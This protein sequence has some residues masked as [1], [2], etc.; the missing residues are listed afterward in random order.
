MCSCEIFNSNS[1][2]ICPHVYIVQHDFERLTSMEFPVPGTVQRLTPRVGER[3]PIWYVME[4][5]LVAET[6][7]KILKCRTCSRKDIDVCE[8]IEEVLKFLGFQD[9]V[10]AKENP[11]TEEWD[12]NSDG[13][14][15]QQQQMLPFPME[16]MSAPFK[17]AVR[18]LEQIGFELLHDSVLGLCLKP[19][20]TPAEIC[21]CGLPFL[22]GGGKL[23]IRCLCIW[24]YTDVE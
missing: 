23:L 9:T 5:G 8:H 21:N 10:L 2:K 1:M 15:R 11:Q 4:G 13:P 17:A 18:K 24:R 6:K 12:F 7:S 14:V 20:L 16:R 22:D 19:H 3:G